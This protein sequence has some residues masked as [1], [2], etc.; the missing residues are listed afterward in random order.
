MPAVRQAT[1]HAEM[2]FKK[3]FSIFAKSIFICA[4]SPVFHCKSNKMKTLAHP[5]HFVCYF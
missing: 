3:H 5:L 1:Q 4:K 2:P